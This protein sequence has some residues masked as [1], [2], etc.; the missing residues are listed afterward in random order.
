MRVARCFLIAVVLAFALAGWIVTQP[1]CVAHGASVVSV[2]PA[3]LRSHV[4][5]LSEEFHPR[6]Y[7]QR[8]NLARCARYIAGEL[9]A[10]SAVVSTQGYTVGSLQF[11]NVIGRFGPATG[12][13]I[14]V[15]AHYDSCDETPGADDNASGVAGLLELARLLA[16]A[17]DVPCRVDLVAYCTEEPPFFGSPDMGS[18]RHAKMLAESGTRVRA[19]IVLEMIGYFRDE[20]W[21]QHYPVG[22]LHLM[23]PSRGNYIGVVGNMRQRDLVK[24]V[25]RSMAGAT[26]LPVCSTC[27]PAWVPGV[28][29]SDHRSYWEFGCPAVM[30]TDTAFYRNGQYHRAGDTADRLDYERMAKVVAGVYAAVLA[31]GPP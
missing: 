4:V 8:E 15:G 18:Y 2:D 31:L 1:G 27:L 3:R 26:D 10:A 17:P 13:V 30:I 19:A 25:K 14:I 9:A 6:S 28:D 22:L 24:A 21:S 11:Q 29:F 23:Y 5:K 12:D 20:R 16:H 7:A